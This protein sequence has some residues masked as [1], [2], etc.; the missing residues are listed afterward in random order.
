MGKLRT[1]AT[2]GIMP[3]LGGEEFWLGSAPTADR[4]L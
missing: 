1:P 2:I 3:F 4:A